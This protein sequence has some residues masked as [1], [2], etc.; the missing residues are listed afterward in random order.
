MRLGEFAYDPC[1]RHRHGHERHAELHE[2]HEH[3]V[4]G[5]AVL[6]GPVLV[7]VV[8]LM[9]SRQ[10]HHMLV[11]RPEDKEG[12]GEEQRPSPD[13]GQGDASPP[14]VA[15]PPPRLQDDLGAEEVKQFLSLIQFAVV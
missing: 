6:D 7:A 2:H 11:Q 8:D 15:R 13:E 3:T 14:G 10:V 9:E 5:P 4:A 1:V 12:G